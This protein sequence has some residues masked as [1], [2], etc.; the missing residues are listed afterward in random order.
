MDILRIRT[1]GMFSKDSLT[2]EIHHGH[3]TTVF[4]K[5]NIS[6]RGSKYCLEFSIA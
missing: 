4:C 1:Q 6:L 2:L 3:P 5:K